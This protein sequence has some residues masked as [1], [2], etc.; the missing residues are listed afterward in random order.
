VLSAF[1]KMDYDKKSLESPTI[2]KV[3]FFNVFI[4]LSQSNDLAIQSRAIS[5][6][7]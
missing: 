3:S 4:F 1:E 7:L 2:K 5:T 6:K